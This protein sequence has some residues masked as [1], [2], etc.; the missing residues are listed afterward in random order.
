MTPGKVFVTSCRDR[1]GVV[2]AACV[3]AEGSDGFSL[4]GIRDLGSRCPGAYRK[5]CAGAVTQVDQKIDLNW[6]M[7]E[8]S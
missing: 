7:L 1:T 6:S 4:S 5:D 8:L 3:G 2:A